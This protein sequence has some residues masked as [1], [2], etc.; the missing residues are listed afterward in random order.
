MNSIRPGGL[1]RHYSNY[2]EPFSDVLS[3]A[4][5]S[6]VEANLPD[7]LSLDTDNKLLHFSKPSYSYAL[8]D[9]NYHRTPIALSAQL[10][11]M[12]FLAEPLWSGSG[13]LISSPR[14]L[15]CYRRNL[16]S[17]SGS[18]SLPRSLRYILTDQGEQIPIVAQELEL[19]AT[20]SVEGNSVKIISVPWKTPPGSGPSLEE[21]VEKEPPSMPLDWLAGNE[22]DP[23][24][25]TFP[26][27]W[28]RLQFRVATANNGR[29]KELQQHFTIKLKVMAALSTGQRVSI[30]EVLSGSV[31][32]RGRSPRNF[33][34][35]REV[36]VG[37]S[38][39]AGRKHHMQ[40]SPTADS[41]TP[42]PNLKR[43]PSMA[44]DP[45]AL[46][47]SPDFLDWRTSPVNA[48]PMTAIPSDN[49]T[50]PPVVALYAHSSPDYTRRPT[51][52]SV[53]APINLSLA[54]DEPRR[55]NETPQGGPAKKLRLTQVLQRSPSFSL[56]TLSAIDESVD[57]LYEYFPLELDDWQEPVDAVYRPHVVHHISM[58]DQKRAIKERSKRYFSSE[59]AS[60]VG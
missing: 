52:R 37:G 18:I 29:R 21:K 30:C 41:S 53:P 12:F 7:P 57:L 23:E 28:K 51:P 34:A 11:G 6:V 48:G 2:D 16:F 20:E 60:S 9:Y 49:F 59:E 22:I 31:I 1:K 10:H 24:C 54:D 46:S 19:S 55:A 42:R 8:L 36:P 44:F 32:V 5:G 47:L 56:N 17:I 3:N 27:S 26:V 14:E 50:M 43:D 39:A 58:P 13:D 4:D 25:A 38:S 40:R 45:N 35:K 33:Q 15:T